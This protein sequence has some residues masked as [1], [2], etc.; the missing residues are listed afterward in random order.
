MLLRPRRAL[1]PDAELQIG[2]LGE[3]SADTLSAPLLEERLVAVVRTGHPLTRGRVTPKRFAASAHV[4]TSRRGRRHGPIDAMLAGDGLS[5]AVIAIAPTFAAALFMILDADAVT[6]LPE[7]LA[8]R[9]ASTMPI[10]VVGLPFP[11]PPVP[12]AMA[13]HRRLDNDAGHRWL[14]TCVT[15]VSRRQ[16]TTPVSRSAATSSTV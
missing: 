16:A 4:V 7:R 2:A 5:R 12:I 10:S 13:W 14:R 1:R 9:A 8:R 6:L 11:L 3:L 15:E